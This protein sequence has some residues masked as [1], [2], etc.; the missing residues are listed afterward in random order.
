MLIKVLAFFFVFMA[1]LMFIYMLC[2]LRTNAIF[3]TIFMLLVPSFSLLAA[4]YWRMGK[5]DLVL[6]TRL[7]VV[8][9]L[10]VDGPGNTVMRNVI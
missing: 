3:V 7:S 4:G 9:G 6:G 10:F 8:S 2:A 5:G 1:L